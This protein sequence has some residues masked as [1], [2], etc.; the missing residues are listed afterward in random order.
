MMVLQWDVSPTTR[1]KCRM[2]ID[3]KGIIRP[4]IVVKRFPGVPG[5]P[6]GDGV[7]KI[8]GNPQDGDGSLDRGSE[9]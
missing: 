7:E 4:H 8:R 1:V 2:V 5:E 9:V 3:N 6:A